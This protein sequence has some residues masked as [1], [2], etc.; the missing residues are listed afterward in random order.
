LL[1]QASP[2]EHSAEVALRRPV[3]LALALLLGC[4][5]GGNVPDAG[6][7]D[8]STPIEIARKLV[9]T[10]PLPP[11]AELLALAHS[12]EAHAMREGT[13]PRA[14]ELHLLSAR[15]FERMWRL[16]G[17]DQDGK[18]ALDLYRAA[19]QPASSPVAC[20]ASLRAAWLAGELAQ[21]PSITYA[22]V[23]R[24][25]RKLASVADAGACSL[26]LAQTLSSLAPACP[27]RTVLDA[28]DRS[29]A[30]EGTL[31]RPAVVPVRPPR[32][33]RV[34]HFTDRDAAR[35]VVELDG[36]AR[37]RVSDAG[38]TR[39]T[40]RTFIELDGV[41]LGDGA[42]T[43]Q[44]HGI[45]SRL[46]AEATIT[47]ARVVLDLDG[48]AYRRAFPLPEPFRIV[49]DVAR[50]PPGF[51]RTRAVLRVVLDPGHGGSDPGAIGRSGVQEKEVTLDIAHRVAPALAK[52]GLQVVLTRDDDRF[53]ALEERTAR[54]NA[55]A[56]D[57]FVSIH[58]NASDAPGARGV[59][60]YV[61]D[62]SRDDLANR[63]AARENATSPA[64]TVE[65]GAILASMRLADHA[66]RSRKLAGL[67]QHATVT[68]LAMKYS[69]V[70][71]GGVH[72]AAFH[73]LVGARMPSVLL[74]TSYVSNAEEEARLGSAD[75]R[76][77]LAD[78]IVNAVRA[79]RE[80]R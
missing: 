24:A 13:G 6:P 19:S 7:A 4:S 58:C 12:V 50:R 66:T 32:V 25:E 10:S 54:A 23:Y 78:G 31:T 48:R 67:L 17:R 56:A 9:E 36:P 65:L 75:Y 59:E 71:D 11:R 45:V 20:D 21:D 37:F 41:D 57:L 22:E 39:H 33:V 70:H 76:E 68:S 27:A 47:G 26:L 18:E 8:A 53:I 49:I 38:G 52:D 14:S 62:T 46:T 16:D 73:V 28:I 77:R 40:S 44:T 51:E 15:L 79:Y 61:L 69:N 35:I 64:A 74:E 72:T 3:L 1:H 29:L 5:K 30:S 63:I 80:G 2:R 42:G 60:T 43:V 55:V 34:G